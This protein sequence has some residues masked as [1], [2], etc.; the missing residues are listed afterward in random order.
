MP[1]E[2]VLWWVF[3][4][5]V[6]F[7]LLLDLLVF[8]RKA[9]EVKIKEAL[10][11]SAVWIS[12]AL[13]FNAVIYFVL[14]QKLALQFLAG[15]LI[16]KSLSVD[17]LFVFLLIFSYFGVPAKYQHRVLFWGIIGAVLTRMVFIFAGVKL[18]E[19]FEWMVYVF[20]AFLIVTGIRML[21]KKDDDIHMERN[22]IMRLFKPI[23]DYSAGFA[24]GRFFYL[25]SGR[26]WLTPLFVVL[27]VVESSD[28]VFAV[29]SVP[30]VLA[31]SK[32]MFIIYSSNIFAILGL[33]ALYFALA[34]LMGMFH[35]LK[36]G[37]AFILSFVGLKMLA[38]HELEKR[39]HE[40]PISI[41]LGVIALALLVSILAS[42][43]R[44]RRAEPK[45]KGSGQ[46]LT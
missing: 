22:L 20:G 33:R 42:I 21:F 36:Y 23:T 32:D 3:G 31:V 40:I 45:D 13:I 2:R 14:G 37:L 4:A 17:N 26:L 18:I 29:D 9:H 43:I 27:L 10:I 39:G 8:N 6:A 12:L 35:Y 46:D 28:V 7:M 1:Q 34:G 44:E 19:K 41:A 24:S 11:W 25:K 5:V 30:A 15:Y 16:E 38:V